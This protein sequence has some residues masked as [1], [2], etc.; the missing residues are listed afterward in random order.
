MKITAQVTYPVSV[1]ID[2]P[3]INPYDKKYPECLESVK[4]KILD[5][6][7]K[8]INTSTIKPII[9]DCNNPDLID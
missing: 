2:V 5:E 8:I 9:H 3:M 4:N 7:E 6:A 1:S